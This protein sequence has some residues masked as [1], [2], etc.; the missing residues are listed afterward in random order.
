MLY[1]SLQ[2]TSHKRPDRSSEHACCWVHEGEDVA[3]IYPVTPNGESELHFGKNERASWVVC[4]AMFGK[5]DFR[6][7][8]PVVVI[9]AVLKK[10]ESVADMYWG[11]YAA[12]IHDKQNDRFVIL[13]DPCG[14]QPV[15]Y[16]CGLDGSVD[17]G[18][19]IDAVI[20]GSGIATNVNDRYLAQYLV[21]GSGDATETGW[22][23]VLS[24]IPG[25]ALVWKRGHRP[26]VIRVWS[27][28]GKR[29]DA[30]F[31]E[32]IHLLKKSMATVFGGDRPIVLELSGGLDSTALAVALNMAKLQERTL[33]VTYIDT[34]RAS[35][36]EVSVAREVAKRCGIRHETYNLQERLPFSPPGC[37]PMVSRPATKLCF[38]AQKQHFTNS[39][40]REGGAF[41]LNG[42]GGD[43]LYLDPPPFGVIIDALTN[44]R[45]RRAISCLTDL[46]VHYRIP[47]WQAFGRALK[48]MHSFSVGSDEQTTLVA[49]NPESRCSQGGGVY[50]DVLSAPSLLLRPARRCQIAALGAIIDEAQVQVWPHGALSI[51]P[52]LFQPIVEHALNLATEDVFSSDHSRIPVRQSVYSAFGLPN[53]WRTD[54]GDIMHPAL[55]GVWKNVNH[56]RDVC[57]QGWS[58]SEG[59]LD[60]VRFDRLIKR[61]VLGFGDGLAEITRVY[62]V[63]IFYRS[64]VGSRI[65]L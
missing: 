60:A 9:D 58:V 3:E 11:M 35:S 36:N 56:I 64:V 39:R 17:V 27:P 7:V 55:K 59:I 52:F 61:A 47:V 53:V 6:K 37:L 28:Y 40:L 26:E 22:E 44:R 45:F 34:Q 30:G 48:E 42:N 1:A 57:L 32:I 49:V 38:L 65:S 13:A 51:M 25:T 31:E 2:F 14:R 46:S 29:F 12:I 20:N 41:F 63:E 23:G 8:D 43:S 19:S 33:A 10:I 62:A 4:G 16:H 18:L 54:K 15:F 5:R 50:D 24:L 21:C